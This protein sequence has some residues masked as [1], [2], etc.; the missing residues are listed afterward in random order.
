LNAA[1]EGAE[2]PGKSERALAPHAWRIVMLLWFTVLSNYLARTLF[3]A[4]HGSLVAAI[5]MSDAQFGLLTSSLLWTYGLASPFAGFLSD[6]FNRSRVIIVTMFLWSL[7]TLLASYC[8]TFEQLIVLRSL[9]GLVE[10]CYMPAALALICDYHRGPTRSMAIA[11]HHSGYVV[12]LGLSGLGGWLAQA[13][14]W[15]FAFALVGS[16]GVLYVVPLALLLRD[17]PAANASA[18][19]PSKPKGDTRLGA[20]LSSLFAL[21][22]F[23]LM[24]AAHAMLNLNDWAVIGWVPLFIQEHFHQ[25]QAAAGVWAT[26]YKN[27]GLILGLFIGGFFADRWSRTNR[28][29]RMFVPAIGL[30][31]GAPGIALM[32]NTS[33]LPLGILGLSLYYLFGAFYES[34]TMPVLCEVVDARYRATAYGLLNCVGFLAAGSGIYVFGILRDL[35]FDLHVVF[36]FA[37]GLC[38]ISALIYCCIKPRISAQGTQAAAVPV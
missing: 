10:A 38:V 2:T 19:A 32:A 28:R 12:G 24:L 29:A 15:H 23:L 33:V 5:P 36:D 1:L 31:I 6:R 27:V 30:M 26:G 16:A 4:M 35:K 25:T 13:Q 34:N 14:S 8:R 22:Y 3:T 11:I 7:T 18:A 21:G 9:M 37:A 20:A 17:V